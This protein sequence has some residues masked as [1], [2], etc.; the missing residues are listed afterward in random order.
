MPADEADAVMRDLIGT[1]AYI[2]EHGQPAEFAELPED[3]S[4]DEDDD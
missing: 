4:P 3:P 2:D 1:N